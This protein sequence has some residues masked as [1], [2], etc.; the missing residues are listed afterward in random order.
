M[1]CHYFSSPIPYSNSNERKITLTDPVQPTGFSLKLDSR[2][3]KPTAAQTDA[4]HPLTF[5][6]RPPGR[7][8]A[9]GPG[10]LG[11]HRRCRWLPA[12]AH[13]AQCL[14]WPAPPRSPAAPA[15]PTALPSP[16]SRTSTAPCVA[17]HPC[18]SWP[19]QPSPAAVPVPGPAPRRKRARTALC[20]G[21]RS[22][23]AP[24][25]SLMAELGRLSRRAER[26]DA[27]L[28]LGL[29]RKPLAVTSAAALA[30][31]PSFCLCTG[32][33]AVSPRSGDFSVS[34][35]TSGGTAASFG[36]PGSLRSRS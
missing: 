5:F 1:H 14:P 6:P 15:W 11:R 33:E 29:R 28:A 23:E 18:G 36:C 8:P 9:A 34:G 32:M 30:R 26:R 12:S 22:P 20:H 13:R 27:G 3:W 4:T 2:K 25:R 10:S 7:S 21:R 16:R 24:G 17:P 31:Q 19:H 35:C